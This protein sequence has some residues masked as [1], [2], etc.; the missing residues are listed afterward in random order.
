MKKK[1]YCS[2][3]LSLL[4]CTSATAVFAE[5]GLK[6]PEFNENELEVVKSENMKPLA[7]V[8]SFSKQQAPI[9]LSKEEVKEIKD[10][11]EKYFKN[12]QEPSVDKFIKRPILKDGVYE[13]GQYNSEALMSVENKLNFYRELAGVIPIEMTDKD[14]EFAQ[15]GAIGLAATQEFTHNLSEKTKPADMSEF[16][17]NKACESAKNS[18]ISSHFSTREYEESFN[19]EFDRY[20]TDSGD[21][22]KRVGHRSW[23][24]GLQGSSFGMGQAKSN[25]KDGKYN[26]WYSTLYV[27]SD[28]N[29]INEKYKKDFVMKW[30]VSEHFPIQLYNRGNITKEKNMRWSVSFNEKGYSLS[31]NVSVELLN[32][33]TGEV[34]NMVND[35]NG[36]E[37]L[38]YGAKPGFMAVGGYNTVVFRPND[39]F[40]IESNTEYTVTVKGVLKDGKPIDYTYTTR[41]VDM[42]AEYVDQDEAEKELAAYKETSKTS[43]SEYKNKSDYREAEQQAITKILEATNTKIDGAKDKIS[44]DTLVKEAKSSLEKVKTDKELTAEEAENAAKE[45][46]A[47][48]ETLKANLAEYKNKSD[49]RES[50]QKAIT[51]I[52]EVT[53]TKIDGAK[54]KASVDTLVKEAKTSL[55]KVKTDKELTAEEAANTAK[56][57]AAYKETSKT[58]LSEYK[59]KSDYRESEQEAIAKIL[60]A[61]NTKID[62]AKDKASINELVKEAKSALDKVKT[63]KELTAE[64]TATAA[65]EL[66]AY[67]ETSKTSLSEY[68]NKSD[69]RETEQEAITKILEATNTKIDGAKDKA[70]IDELVKEA[71]SALDKVKTDKE[72]TA[73]EAA[74][75]EKEL[76]DYKK[77]SKASL[78]E[79][80][81]KSDYRETEQ[82]VIT[83]I[84]EATNTKI[85]GAKDKASVDTLVKEAKTSLDKVKTDKEL[86]AEEAAT[87]AKELAAYKETSKTS[88]SE[89]KNKSDYRESEQQAITKILEA[90]N[91]K[92]DGAKDKV[93]IDTLVKEAKSSLDKVKTDK[94]LTAEEANEAK[95]LAEYKKMSKVDLA[96]YKNKADYRKKQQEQMTIILNT[97]NTKIDVATTKATIDALVK[98][99]KISLD[100]L[101][102]DKELTAEEMT[103]SSVT[104]TD[105]KGVHVLPIDKNAKVKLSVSSKT[106]T[107][108]VD[109]EKYKL[110]DLKEMTLRGFTIDNTVSFNL[111]GIETV[112]LDNVKFEKTLNISGTKDLETLVIKNSTL[113]KVKI[114]S[115]SKLTNL[116]IDNTVFNDDLRIYSNRSLETAVISNS[117]LKDELKQYSNHKNYKAQMINN[118]FKR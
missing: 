6:I 46:A 73:E 5:G 12:M 111:N 104:Y 32:K 2:I 44:I 61:T 77:T 106:V 88:L 83:K 37:L 50:E 4:L 78:S 51:K 89:Y 95:D 59:N 60:E 27:E 8:K 67:K 7:S 118:E 56:E 33:R 3:V 49:Y 82:K 57:L 22:N 63:D 76:A 23:V 54:D 24:L 38:A 55:D 47:Y 28:F 21:N 69:Y 10:L 70:S 17:W 92:I 113:D 13:L 15:Y 36:G 16:F 109:K 62:G 101:K 80:K 75:A 98:E 48:K 68:K 114:H 58:S 35:D 96:K 91:T 100:N 31:D 94:E 26:Q 71:K 97:T 99:A 79:Y 29:S 41:M 117:I 40:Q 85:D 72:L 53:N 93:S 30:P 14:N 34:I 25:E 52:L 18:N 102:T 110:Q 105:A 103:Q 39:D 65:K 20:I 45:L 1:T 90:T 64:E 66:A 11:Q 116:T 9:Y 74:T 107:I 43:L 86:T 112:T 115:A 108:R 42:D 87:A 84:L 19:Y 81:N